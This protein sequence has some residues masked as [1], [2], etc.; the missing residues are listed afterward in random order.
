[1]TIYEVIEDSAREFPRRTA[2]SYFSKHCTYEEFKRDIDSTASGL[3]SMG[4]K[5][6]DRVAVTAMNSPETITGIYALNKIGAVAVM[7]NPKSPAKELTGQLRLTKAKAIIYSSLVEN[8]V[9]EAIQESDVTL[10]IRI[11]SLKG[12]SIKF[13]VGSLW[14]NLWSGEKRVPFPERVKRISFHKLT[15]E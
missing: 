7:L 2:Y 12:L 3:L 1:M 11:N 13:L 5:S 8:S 4:I 9:N 6:G 14:K 15:G 10:A